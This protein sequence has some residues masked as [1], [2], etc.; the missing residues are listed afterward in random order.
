MELNSTAASLTNFG[1]ISNL[2]QKPIIA[3][4]LSVISDG[5][6]AFEA[7]AP[8]LSPRK[9][10]DIRVTSGTEGSKSTTFMRSPNKVAAGTLAAVALSGPSNSL[11]NS[12]ANDPEMLLDVSAALLAETMGISELNT[13]YHNSPPRGG[14]TTTTTTTGGGSRHASRRSSIVSRTGNVSLVGSYRPL[15]QGWGEEEKVSGS[16]YTSMADVSSRD[17]VA[18]EEHS[19]TGILVKALLD[20][21]EAHTKSTHD[22]SHV[23]NAPKS[24]LHARFAKHTASSISHIRGRGLAVSRMAP[25][26]VNVNSLVR[27]TV[28]RGLQ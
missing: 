2:N 15:V 4:K 28:A 5:P 7:L 21:D 22:A 11:S 1:N 20:A 26:F 14:L 23:T 24:L 3:P 25:A 27:M 10:R 16:T 18:Q 9:S 19:A 17:L 6:S 13:K 12:L 8:H